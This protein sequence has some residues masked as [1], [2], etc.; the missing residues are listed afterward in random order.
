M[1]DIYF[2]GKE[3]GYYEFSNYYPSKFTIDFREYGTVEQYFQA[4]KYNYDG[5]DEITQE[6]YKLI[7][8][9]DSPQK[10]KSLGRQQIHRFGNKWLINKKKPELGYV[11]QIINY[12]NNQKIK[13]IMNPNW[14][15]VKDDVMMTALY[16]K[17][18]S[19]NK[20]KNILLSTGEAKIHENSPKDLYWGILGQDKLGILLTQLREQLK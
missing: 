15:L 13:P 20:L 7:Q 1:G 10:A 4:E 12:F 17:F 3:D 5:N 8:E 11:N 16:H 19:N 2:Y 9:C 6:Y 18:T 14:E